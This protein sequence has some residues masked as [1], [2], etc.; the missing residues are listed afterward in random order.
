MNLALARIVVASDARISAAKTEI[1]G[2]SSLLIRSSRSLDSERYGLLAGTLVGLFSSEY[3]S[4]H[5]EFVRR[6]ATR[7]PYPDVSPADFD[8]CLSFVKTFCDRKSALWGAIGKVD[9]GRGDDGHADLIDALAL[10]PN[11]VFDEILAAPG[12]YLKIEGRMGGE[13]LALLDAE[14]FNEMSLLEAI[15]TYLPM[16]SAEFLEVS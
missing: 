13:I 4:W 3:A 7:Q 9:S 14:L 6:G 10:A 8:E 12:D 2:A 1:R 11:H 5:E 15:D 16:A